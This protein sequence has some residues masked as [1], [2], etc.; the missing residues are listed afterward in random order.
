[1][2]NIQWKLHIRKKMQ[3]SNTTSAVR[4]KKAE[5]AATWAGSPGNMI[6][7]SSEVITN[8]S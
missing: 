6:T 8:L 5:P 3:V 7:T 2:D 4:T 1:M